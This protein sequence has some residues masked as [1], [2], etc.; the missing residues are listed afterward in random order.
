MN[1]YPI[2]SF[3]V[4]NP[5]E[6]L[7]VKTRDF[8]GD[9]ET[10]MRLISEEPASQPSRF[11]VLDGQQRLQSL[12]IGFFGK[13]DQARMYFKVDSDPVAEE[14]DLRY[15]FAFIGSEEN[16]DPHWVKPIELVGLKIENI[17]EFVSERFAADVEDVK[18]RIKKNLGKFVRVFNLDEKII[19]Q[20]ITADMEYDDVLEVF[21]RVNSGGIILTKSDLVFSTLVLAAPKLERDFTELVDTLNGDKSFD[22]DIDFLSKSSF[23]VHDKKARYDVAK[24]EDADFVDKLEHKFSSFEAA[25][26]SMMN[27][28]ESD[29]KILSKRFLKS[30]L[31]LIPIIDFIMKQPHQQLSEGQ[32]TALRQYLYMSFFMKFYSYGADTKLDRIHQ[33]LTENT[34]SNVFP[35]KEIS[36]YLAN[37]TEKTY[38]FSKDMLSNLD[39]VLNI[40]QGGVK[41][42][43]RRKGWSLERDHIFP[44]AMLEKLHMPDELINNVGNLRLI[45]KTRNIL[46]S[47]G[48]P[49]ENT[50]FFGSND[51][52]LRQLFIRARQDLTI[53]NFEKFVRKREQLT[54]AQVIS[55]LGLHTQ[56]D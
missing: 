35:L 1:D 43:P 34:T 4:W 55:F 49:E 2:G 33:I 29:A 17:D 31:A 6:K 44:R 41:E 32:A 23:V 5:P 15:Q 14:N 30:D 11:L 50:D 47:D 19:F 25:L 9:Y 51:S 20:E 16:P 13:Y 46:K 39:L 7:K 18:K 36:E 3:L 10:G 56:L 38:A 48:L 21:V 26:T 37:R 45:T 27:F 8:I 40:I 24:L 42:I 22:F 28:L 53:D 54:Y 52:E 12:Y